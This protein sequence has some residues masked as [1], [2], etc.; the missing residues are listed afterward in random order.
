MLKYPKIKDKE[1]KVN[2][3]ILIG[4]P[5]ILK[6]DRNTTVGFFLVSADGSDVLLP[7]RY[8]T[9]EMQVGDEVEV[10]IYTDS[11]DRIVATTERPIAMVDE[12]GFFEVVGVTEFGAFVDWGLPK[13][14]FVPNNVQKRAFRIG[15][16]RI[17]RVTYDEQTDRLIGVEN[18]MNYVERDIKGLKRFDE[19]QMLVIAKT[20]MGYKVIVNNSYEGMIFENEIFE[21]VNVGDTKTGY[22]KLVRDDGK[23][24]LSLAPIGEQKKST[25]SE[26]VFEILSSEKSGFL[27]Y[28]YKSDA[29]DISAVFGLSKKNF[30]LSLTKL[31]SD[32]KIQISEDGIRLA[33]G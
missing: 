12:F 25:A 1:R 16:W 8:I 28:N 29:E 7:S 24:D 19:V 21:E 20:P 13:D 9:K 32:G 2:E 4:E 15:D 31:Q 22:V 5:N 26:R 10:F 14:L 33:Q 27:P 30:K 11:E 17:L 3:R 6:I 18:I 23:L